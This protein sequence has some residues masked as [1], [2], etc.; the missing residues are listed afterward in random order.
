MSA[1]RYLKRGGNVGILLDQDAGQQGV[2]VPFFGRLASTLPTAADISLRTGA[3]IWCGTSWRDEHGLHHLVMRGPVEI[4][5]TG[6]R[7]RDT[8]ALTTACNA[9]LEERIREHPE[10]WLWVHRRWK[11]R[12]PEE[13]AT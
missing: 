7:K 11:T 3:P 1:L 9:A 2:F 13:S 4:E 6:D 5:R 8:L 12:P 10:Q